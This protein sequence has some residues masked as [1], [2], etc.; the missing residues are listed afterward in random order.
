MREEIRNICI[1]S[2]EDLRTAE[3]IIEVGRFDVQVLGWQLAFGSAM[4]YSEGV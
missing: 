1:Q 2:E 4:L 3:L